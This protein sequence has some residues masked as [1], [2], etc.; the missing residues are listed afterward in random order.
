MTGNSWTERAISVGFP[1][2]VVCFSTGAPDVVLTREKGKNDKVRKLL[3]DRGIHCLEV[4]MVETE[5]GP[6]FDQLPHVL[7]TETFDWVCIT[8]PEAASVFI[9]GWK[10]AGKPNVTIAVVGNGTGRVLEATREPTLQPQFTPSVANAEHFGP[11]LPKI[12]QGNDTILYPS[13]AKA[14][15]LLQQGLEQRNFRVL[16]LNTYNTVTVKTLHA[17]TLEQVRQARVVAIASPSAL[18]AWVEH[19]GHHVTSQMTIA[20][21]GSTSAKAAEKLGLGRVL[22]PDNPGVETFVETIIDALQYEYK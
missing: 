21:I 2:P 5:Q 17:E 7:Q 9:Q 20:A 11:E 3:E 10:E 12:P 15:T 8:S 13:S 18:K 4:P 16:R 1:V 22:Y 6:D 14:S 19:V